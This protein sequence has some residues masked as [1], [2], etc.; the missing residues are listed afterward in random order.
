[1]NETLHFS[2][3]I[4]LIERSNYIDTLKE[5]TEYHLNDVEK[6]TELKKSCPVI[7]TKNLYNDNK[8]FQFCNEV[9]SVSKEIVLSEGYSLDNHELYISEMWCQ[10]HHFSSGHEKHVH[11][12]SSVLTGFYFFQED[13]KGCKVEFS[14]PR[15]AKEYGMILPVRNPEDESLA[16]DIITLT[17]RL[18]YF[19][20]TNSW[21]PHTIT[22][23]ESKTP[24][25]FVHFNIS[26]VSKD[27]M[28]T[29]KVTVI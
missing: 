21:L 5:V 27:F 15:P 11:G 24:F 22:R 17:P 1:M 3:P 7:Q 12:L 14:D 9:I 6:E 13:E 18:G 2:T 4:Y 25:K 20:F 10:E 26:A 16:S 29:S 19:T 8:L 23:N 28:Q